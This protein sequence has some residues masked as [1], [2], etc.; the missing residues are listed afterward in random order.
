MTKTP[1]ADLVMNM[2][3][4]VGLVI[5]SRLTLSEAVLSQLLD[6]Q[7]IARSG[8]GLENIDIIYCKDRNIQLYNSP[9]GNRNAVAEHGFKGLTDIV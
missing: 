2:K 3:D 5:R 4:A 9:E 6:L 7:F 8:S 1:T